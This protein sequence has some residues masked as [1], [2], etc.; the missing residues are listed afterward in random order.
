MKNK[1]LIALV[2]TAPILGAVFIV[3]ICGGVLVSPLFLI[4]YLY[5]EHKKKKRRAS[6]LA[7][8]KKANPPLEG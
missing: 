1:T 4:G 7:L 5:T 2:I 3:A 6:I 8:L